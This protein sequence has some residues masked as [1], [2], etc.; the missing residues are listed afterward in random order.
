MCT[1]YLTFD[2]IGLQELE[3]LMNAHGLTHATK[4][5]NSAQLLNDMLAA[6]ARPQRQSHHGG[7][8]VVKPEPHGDTPMDDVMEEDSLVHNDPMMSALSPEQ[9]HHTNIV[10]DDM[11]DM[12]S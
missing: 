6:G 7:S 9:A 8:P 4:E 3:M 2:L 5:N 10:M 11:S 1:K 12:L